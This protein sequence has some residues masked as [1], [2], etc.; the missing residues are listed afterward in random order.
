MEIGAGAVILGGIIIGSHSIIGAN[1]VV[2]DDV[3]PYSVVAGVPA[4]VIRRI[5]LE[6]R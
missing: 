4:K 6:S 1:A 2:V 5:T 3:P